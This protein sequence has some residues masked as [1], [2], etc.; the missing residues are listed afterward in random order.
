VL[1]FAVR[2]GLSTNG[3]TETNYVSIGV[4]DGALPLAIILVARAVHRNPRLS[5]LLGHPLGFTTVDVENTVTRKFVSCSL[6]KVDGEIAIPV[7]KGIGVVV[8]RDLETRTL[9]PSDRTI[10]ICHLENRLESRDQPLP[11]YQLELAVSLSIQSA[12]A[13]MADR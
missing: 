7:S 5:P 4:G 9:E 8:E 1:N 13:V 11:R 2:G 10:H 12:Q 6:R 3:A